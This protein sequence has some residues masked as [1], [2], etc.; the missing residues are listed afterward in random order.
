MFALLLGLAC[1]SPEPTGEPASA[2]L[3]VADAQ[4]T[5]SAEPESAAAAG[6]IG[7][8]PILPDPVV[9]G[10]ISA[11]A[12]DAGIASQL[13]AIHRCYQEEL[14]NHA[15]LAGKVL[16]R[17]TI[18]RDGTVSKTAIKSSSLRHPPTETCLSARLSEAR[19]PALERGS[20]AII[21]YPFI[22]P[23]S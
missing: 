22:F 12:V 7:G 5:A 14:A 10:G 15:G 16:V 1:T 11:S 8:E 18:A 19:F 13:D 6:S 3:D 23:P 4:P 9:L 17:F 2:S 21:T 20:V